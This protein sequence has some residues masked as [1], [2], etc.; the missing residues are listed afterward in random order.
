MPQ[1]PLAFWFDISL[2]S[3]GYE[4]KLTLHRLPPTSLTQTIL[5]AKNIVI[6]TGGRPKYPTNVSTLFFLS[7]YRHPLVL[8][9]LF[10]CYDL[11]PG[12]KTKLKT[13]PER[14]GLLQVPGA[15]EHGITSDDVFWLKKS[16]GK[17]WGQPTNTHTQRHMQYYIIWYVI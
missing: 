4:Q 1:R 9:V 12:R 13:G 3:E 16:P 14:F 7:L 10:A 15:A 5:T 8:W 2:F 17:T 6:A 11:L